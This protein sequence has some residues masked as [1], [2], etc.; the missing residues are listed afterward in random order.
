MLTLGRFLSHLLLFMLAVATSLAQ[1]PAPENTDSLE[2][3]RRYL[4]QDKAEAALEIT[5]RLL[6]RPGL[7][8]AQKAAVMESYLKAMKELG[9]KDLPPARKALAKVLADA[10]TDTRR[11][12]NIWWH[13]G[14]LTHNQ[15]ELAEAQHYFE[16]ALENLPPGDTESHYWL[17]MS[18]GVAQVQ[19]GNFAEATQSLLEAERIHDR[20]GMPPNYAL[21]QNLSGLFY[22]LKDWDKSLEYVKKA[23]AIANEDSH[24]YTWALFNLGDIYYHKKDYKNAY[25]YLK[26]TLD[27]TPEDPDAWLV[28]GGVLLELGQHRDALDALNKALKLYQDHGTLR[29]LGL[30][31]RHLGRT[32]SSLGN[33]EKAIEHFRQA[34]SLFDRQDSPPE[35]MQLYK[36]LADEL[37]QA[38]RYAEALA[39][40]KKHEALHDKLLNVEI[41]ARIAKLKSL[42]ELEKKKRTLAELEKKRALDRQT[43]TRLELQAAHERTLR[44]FLLAG[45]VFAG[46]LMLL[47]MGVA[48]LR[49]R[50]HQELRS[51][52]RDIE[53]LNQK[54]QETSVRDPLTGLYNRRY[55]TQ[56]VDALIAER[57]GSADD[58]RQG[59]VLVILADLDRFKQINDTWGHSIGDQVLKAFAETFSH[60]ARR[61]D[62]PVRWGGE[63]FLLLCQD[64]D[65]HQGAKLCTR[66]RRQLSELEIDADGHPLHVTCSFGIAPL[67]VHPDLPPHWSW[68]IKLADA[69]LYAAKSAGRDRCVGYALRNL[70]PW[71][72]DDNLDVP[73]LLSE[74]ALWVIEAEAGE[75]T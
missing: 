21:Y 39:A 74:D 16:K 10:A 35:R 30:T 36:E 25:R 33:H 7:S 70:P 45:L 24:E 12:M 63:E 71:L 40:L 4:A 5:D 17:L 72:D 31:H 19:L 64:M 62:I 68:T 59:P 55:L 44:W 48:R 42:A 69:A 53:A 8:S 38:G 61:S 2:L 46:L 18:I 34:L 37:E 54:L 47:L 65:I 66:I 67:P 75:H 15:G 6:A 41:K 9:R 11:R 26:A 13:L 22:Y 57:E 1:Q 23:L 14:V 3:A 50:L 28:L 56:E 51:Q 27:R 43:I 52:H 58:E 73:R 49:K 32:W 20:A 60:C 29:D